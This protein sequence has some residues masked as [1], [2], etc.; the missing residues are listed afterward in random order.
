MDSVHRNDSDYITL[1]FR[2]EAVSSSPL[3]LHG[4]EINEAF[5]N[6]TSHFERF[7]CFVPWES[8]HKSMFLECG[9][10]GRTG[11]QLLPLNNA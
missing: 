9:H 5:L 1:H 2:I 4:G 3:C 7:F 6:Q 11:L 10:V 8:I